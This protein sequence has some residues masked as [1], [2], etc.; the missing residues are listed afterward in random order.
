MSPE[1]FVRRE[2]PRLGAP[3]DARE[4]ERARRQGHA[5]GYAEGLR[6]AAQQARVEAER[7]ETARTAARATD[8][9]AAARACAAVEAAAASLR[10][11]TDRIADLATE[12]IWAL[13]VELAETI[14]ET[15][16]SDP[17]RAART[18]LVRAGNAVAA[19]ETADAVVILS[20]TDA[21]TL[22]RLGE[23]PQGLAVES[24]ASLSPGDAVVHVPDG[25]V[26]LR[27]AAALARARAALAEA[28]S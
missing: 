22:D 14:L 28:A 27:V 18:A 11:R 9:E 20:D 10:E 24:S 23:R 15:E 17:T 16:L 21:E 1:T 2:I 4:R 13:A 8:A 6:L 5:L 19:A 12:R 3:A 25:E 26:D 7:A